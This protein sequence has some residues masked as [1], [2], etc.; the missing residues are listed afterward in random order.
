MGLAFSTLDYNPWHTTSFEAGDPFRWNDPGHGI[1]PTATNSR[2]PPRTPGNS[3]LY[4]GNALR[5]LSNQGQGLQTINR[6][7]RPVTSLGQDAG[8]F[9]TYDFP[10]GAHGTVQSA[11]FSLKGYGAADQPTLYFNYFLDTEDAN[12][13]GQAARDTFRVFVASDDPSLPSDPVFSNGIIQGQWYTVGTN[14]VVNDING[15]PTIPADGPSPFNVQPLHDVGDTWRQ[16]R[17]DLAPFAGLENIRLRFDFSTAGS[18]DTP[19]FFGTG[20]GGEE[21]KVLPA[22]ELR[23][24]QTFRIDDQ[25]FEF[26]LGVTMVAPTG[27]AIADGET[28]TINDGLILPVSFE[29]DNDNTFERNI[30][31]ANGSLFRDGDTFTITDGSGVMQAFEF[32]SGYTLVVPPQGGI[33]DGDTFTIDDGLGNANS[34]VTYEFDTQDPQL[35]DSQALTDPSHVRV[36]IN[37]N[38]SLVIPAAGGGFGGVRNGD[39]FTITDQNNTTF[40]FEYDTGDGVGQTGGNAHIAI[41][42]TAVSSQDEVALATEAAIDAQMMNPRWTPPTSA[43]ECSRSGPRKSASTSA[44]RRP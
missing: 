10:G 24:G 41:P 37:G 5:D 8:A 6:E 3:S 16:A 15:N 33:M 14:N 19:R 23:D 21:L 40:I 36:N 28:F 7:G 43:T 30:R 4:F 44:A 29:F 22:S 34:L 2:T 26:D 17:I 42:I 9:N 35:P 27:D 20:T 39:T 13:A 31:A 11:P 32:E 12:S 1:E 38:Q 18:M 25:D